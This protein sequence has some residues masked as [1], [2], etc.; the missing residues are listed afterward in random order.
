MIIGI[1]GKNAAGKGEVADRLKEKGFVYFS[2]SDIVR[3]E[4]TK[5]GLEHTRY[6]LINVGNKLREE[7]GPQVLAERI[8]QKIRE[9]K[10]KNFVVDSIRNPFEA[11]ELLK[12]KEFLLVGVEASVKLRFERSIERN[13]EGDAKTLKEFKEYEEKEN[14]EKE[15]NQQL[16]ETFKLAGK[17][18]SNNGS[19]EDLHQKVDDLLYELKKVKF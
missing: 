14:V 19:L 17:V 2:L 4:S 12:S 8:M 1:T 3:E 9:S 11:K 15:T 5:M 13:R 16:D 7:H 6:D 18:I 10:D